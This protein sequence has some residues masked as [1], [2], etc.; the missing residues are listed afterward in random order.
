MHEVLRFPAHPLLPLAPQAQAFSLWH[1]TGTDF[2][3][4]RIGPEG[5]RSLLPGYLRQ[6]A[7][8]MH[9]HQERL[10]HY[11]QNITL[12]F[13][14]LSSLVGDASAASM[15]M[16]TLFACTGLMVSTPIRHCLSRCPIRCTGAG[17]CSPLRAIQGRATFQQQRLE[18]MGHCATGPTHVGLSQQCRRSSHP[19]HC[20][21]MKFLSVW[22]GQR[23][24]HLCRRAAVLKPFSDLSETRCEPASVCTA[25][26]LESV[27]SVESMGHRNGPMLYKGLQRHSGLSV[28]PFSSSSNVDG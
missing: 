23:R 9:P 15:S 7:R 20:W 27:V 12:V 21:W 13:T 18:C 4:V 6:R 1:R 16:M 25:R 28:H 5:F 11:L 26:R 3:G 14:H 22:E 2:I 17:Q 10:E 8:L 24:C 19:L